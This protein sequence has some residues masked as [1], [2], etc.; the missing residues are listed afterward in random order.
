M[1]DFLQLKTHMKNDHVFF[2][3]AHQF[4]LRYC[5]YSINY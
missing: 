3:S 5:I 4:P 2:D 1:K